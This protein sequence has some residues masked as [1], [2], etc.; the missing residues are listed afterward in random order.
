M[1]L[2]HNNSSQRFSLAVPALAVILLLLPQVSGAQDIQEHRDVVYGTV[3]G[4][5]LGLDILHAGEH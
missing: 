5:E 3:D 4:T 2:T 1:H